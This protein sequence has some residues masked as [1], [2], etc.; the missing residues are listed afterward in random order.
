[1]VNIIPAP[2]EVSNEA[3]FDPEIDILGRKTFGESLTRLVQA[4]PDGGVIALD[5]AWGEGKSTFIK[6]WLG[7]MRHL[8]DQPIQSINFDAFEHDYSDDPFICLSAE[9]LSFFHRYHDVPDLKEKAITVGKAVGKWGLNV[10]AKA[11]T[12]NLVKDT[13]LEDVGEEISQ[14]LSQITDKQIWARMEAH[15]NLKQNIS[16]FRTQLEANV[17]QHA[18]G[19]LVFVID[20]L[21]RCRPDFSVA[22][23]EQVKH[24]FSAKGVVFVLVLNSKQMR[25]SVQGVYGQA[26]DSERYLQKFVNIWTSL[27]PKQQEKNRA[28]EYRIFIDHLIDK[29]DILD[30]PDGLHNKYVKQIT[31]SLNEL[32]NSFNPSL[33]ELEKTATNIAMA[34]AALDPK[35]WRD[36][37]SLT[38]LA[39][40]KVIDP[41]LFEGLLHGNPSALSEA[42]NRTNL[43]VSTYHVATL[44]YLTLSEEEYGE[45]LR[46]SPE[47]DDY[48]IHQDVPLSFR[49]EYFEKGSFYLKSYTKA[50]SLF[51]A[52]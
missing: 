51:L 1:M 24:L 12:L 31:Q 47:E 41:K 5:S 17:Q 48:R 37:L 22:V 29:M 16:D 40:I 4:L 52:S 34:L 43:R 38:M 3:G 2:V 19:K 8:E 39:I 35:I 45:T 26:I 7:Y 27:P 28:M 20:E 33:R 6:M 46:N 30:Q 21:D 10:A 13:D 9:L 23:V 25:E 32:A 18:N 42:R 44:D 36:P 50:M 49:D 14:A 11:L 15:K